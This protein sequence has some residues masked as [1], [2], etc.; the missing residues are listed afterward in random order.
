MESVKTNVLDF[1]FIQ[2]PKCRFLFS[3]NVVK[4]SKWTEGTKRSCCKVKKLL[5][6]SNFLLNLS[7]NVGT[8]KYNLDKEKYQHALSPQQQQQKKNNPQKNRKQKPLSWPRMPSSPS[9]HMARD[10]AATHTRRLGWSDSA[11]ISTG[12]GYFTNLGL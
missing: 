5:Q 6:D 1:Y 2:I 11:L 10:G 7:R 8:G 3:F 12:P 4:L 9:E